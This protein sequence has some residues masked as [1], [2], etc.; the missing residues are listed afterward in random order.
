M[1]DVLVS[2]VIPVYNGSNY[3]NEAIDSALAQT[4]KNCEIIVVNDGS[5][6]DGRTD[7]I[8]K[9]YGDKIRYYVK[10]NGGVASAVNLGISLMNGDY[11]S[12]LS[13]DDF[14]HPQKV[15][16]QIEALKSS[17][18]M[19]AIV[20]SNFDVL[21]IDSDKLLHH[22]WLNIYSEDLLTDSCFAPLFLAIHGCS[23][24]VHKSNFERVGL[25]DTE[26]KATQDSVWLF[27]ALRGRKSL[28]VEDSLFVAR[29]HLDRGQRTMNCHEPEYNTMFIN[30]CEELSSDEKINFCGSVYNFYLQLFYLLKA[31]PK[32]NSCLD[33]M[34]RKIEE[35]KC[36]KS[37][38]TE[39]IK[40][41]IL[42]DSSGN[43][44]K[45]CIFGA[46]LNGKSLLN[47]FS[48]LN[49]SVEYFV[50]NDVSKSGTLINNTLCISFVEY[51]KMKDDYVIIVSP[52]EP[53]EILYQLKYNG[54]PNIITK[55]ELNMILFNYNR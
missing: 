31:S 5:N 51:L 46:G 34:Q 6:D 27:N 19:T 14:Y 55:K 45:L 29:D 17:N 49:I 30:F 23:I 33:Y 21:N 52:A 1:E 3:L 47:L 16:K 9:S 38:L 37:E 42:V 53:E 20:H 36:E 22:N 41:R 11:F 12:W 40:K 25:Y 32:A 2:I 48:D 10:K 18:D 26:L 13:H 35:L 4:Y 28:F 24:L 50:D 39:G 7:E 44:K 15:E 8:C 54:I 43:E